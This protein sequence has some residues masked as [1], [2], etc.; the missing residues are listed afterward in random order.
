MKDSYFHYLIYFSYV[1]Y[2]AIFVNFFDDPFYFKLYLSVFKIFIPLFLIIRFNPFVKSKLTPLDR[3][4][5]FHGATQ[6]LS[7]AAIESVFDKFYTVT[8][9]VLH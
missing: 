1:C 2:I 6:L 8:N 7:F 4:I 9:R 3:K 5:I